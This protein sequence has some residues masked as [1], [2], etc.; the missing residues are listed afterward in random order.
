MDTDSAAKLVYLVLLGSAVLF[1]YVVT[2]R[3][4]LGYAMQQAA[5]WALLFAG[6]MAAY[7]LKDEIRNAVFQ[8]RMTISQDGHT[9]LRRSEDGHFYATAKVNGALIRFLVDTGATGIV[10]SKPDAALSGIDPDRLN[11]LGR[12]RT[13]NGVIRTAQVELDELQL[14]QRTFRNLLASV[15]DS[16]LEISLLGQSFLSRYRSIEITGDRLILKL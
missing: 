8:P 3:R 6:V 4:Q 13:A 15:S 12:A 11:Y 14:A 7:G 5:A 10:L 2:V 9:E 1:W 16:D